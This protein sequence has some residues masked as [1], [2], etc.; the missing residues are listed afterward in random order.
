M[1]NLWRNLIALTLIFYSA[2]PVIAAGSN[3]AKALPPRSML[4]LG[5]IATTPPRKATPRFD[6]D[7]LPVPPLQ[8]AAWHPPAA[9]FPSNYISATRLLFDQGMADPRGCDY[10]EIEVGTGDVWSGDGGVVATH[11]WVLPEKKGR[12]FAIC[13]NGLVYPAFSVG[14]PANLAADVSNLLAHGTTSWRSALPESVTVLPTSLLG[15][16]GCLLLRLGQADLAKQVW[17]AQLQREDLPRSR[18]FGETPAN[19]LSQTSPGSLPD[20][21]PYL[22]WASDWAWSLFDRMICAHM[23]DDEALALL[24]ARELAAVQPKIEAACAMR[25][26]KRPESWNPPGKTNLPYLD[27]LEQFPQISADLERRAINGCPPA[28]GPSDWQHIADQGKRIKILIAALEFVRGRQMGQPG[29]VDLAEDP[30]VQA[31]V[32]EK[33]AAVEPLL[34]CAEKDVRLTESVGFGRD[35]FRRRKVISVSNAAVGILRIILQADFPGGAPEMR[36]YWNEYKGLSLEDRCYAILQDDTANGRWLEAAQN[37]TRPENVT[38]LGY[39]L[40]RTS[41]APASAPIRLAGEILRAKQNPSVTTLLRH[42]ALDLPANNPESYDLARACQMGLALAAWDPVQA[43]EVNQTLVHRAWMAVQYSGAPLGLE[44]SRLCLACAKAGDFEPLQDYA[45]W[46]KTTSPEQLKFQTMECLEPLCRFFTNVTL[47]QVADALFDNN[48]SP[49]A[50]LPWNGLGFDDPVQSDLVQVPAFRRLLVR[51]LG[52]TNASGEFT[53]EGKAADGCMIGFSM[54]NTRGSR[55]VS[56]FDAPLPA[57]G[58]TCQ[59]RW[60]D[61][62]AWDLSNSK[63]IDFFNPFAPIEERNKQIAEAKTRLMHQKEE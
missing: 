54:D 6:G 10:C 20:N 4:T 41:P 17:L 29:R 46:L 40:S 39:G 51:E 56:P 26:F 43:R 33:D 31:L 23:R 44:I 18:M 7:K 35:F 25:G 49:W 5:G 24:S 36:A 42:R 63:Q 14:S 34:D 21:D 47:A 2:P 58:A 12:K 38:I 1:K 57:A 52:K 53:F 15:V 45:A 19:D 50:A 13:W 60:C 55:L 9:N 3:D 11:G 61:W 22:A 32:N 30:I 8:R 16:K 59:F 28:P 62:I 37:I 48:R 27:F